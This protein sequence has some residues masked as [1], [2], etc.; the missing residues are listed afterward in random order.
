MEGEEKELLNTRFQFRCLINQTS[1][2]PVV[3]FLVGKIEHMIDFDTKGL[4]VS[5]KYI[6]WHHESLKSDISNK[7]LYNYVF[8]FGSI[9]EW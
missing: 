4:V 9:F 2:A 8:E 5:G 7:R 6:D 3:F 1:S